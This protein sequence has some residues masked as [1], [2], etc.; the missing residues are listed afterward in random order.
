MVLKILVI[1]KL[2]NLGK[3]SEIMGFG[4]LLLENYKI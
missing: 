1:R 2:L 3:D 4:K